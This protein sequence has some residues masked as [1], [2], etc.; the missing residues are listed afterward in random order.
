M[1]KTPVGRLR[2]VGMLE[3]AS[4]LVLLCIAMPLKYLAGMPQMVR[5][6]GWVHGVLFVL[7]VG[8][9]LEVGA[10]RRWGLGRM[11]VAFAASLVPFGPFLFDARLKREEQEARAQPDVAPRR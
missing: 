7:Y 3:G 5:S 4:F 6:V 1:L 10:V 8:A 11:A 9:V 2:A